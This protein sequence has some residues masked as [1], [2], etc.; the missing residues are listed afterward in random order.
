M[1]DGSSVSIIQGFDC[2]LRQLIISDDEGEHVIENILD[3]MKPE[4]LSLLEMLV[5]VKPP[6]V[7]QAASVGVVLSEIDYLVNGHPVDIPINDNTSEFSG[8]SMLLE[9]HCSES[10]LLDGLESGISSF[11]KAANGGKTTATFFLKIAGAIKRKLDRL[12]MKNSGTENGG[13]FDFPIRAEHVK[14]GDEYWYNPESNVLLEQSR[15]VKVVKIHRDD[16]RICIS[17]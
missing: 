13:S 7:D 11:I 9:T 5:V 16:S 15:K 14:E 1:E 17:L 10:F 4:M 6:L 12:F 2:I 3:S 8:I